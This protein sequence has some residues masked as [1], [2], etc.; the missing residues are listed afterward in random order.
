MRYPA[1]GAVTRFLREYGDELA[2]QRLVVFG[3]NAPYFLDATEMSRLTTYFGV[4]SKTQPFLEN[5]VRGLFRAFTTAG[6]PPVSVP[7]TRFASLSERLAP[8]PTAVMPLQVKSAEGELLLAN[9]A[10]GVTAPDPAA[11]AAAETQPVDVGDT[12][13]LSVGPIIDRNGHPVPDGT[14]VEFDLKFDDEELAMAVDP[15]LTRGGVAA[16]DVAVERSGTLRVAATAGGASSGEP[17]LLVIVPPPA[18]T[19]EAPA[20]ATDTVSAGQQP[21]PERV[22]LMTLLIALF[23]IVVTLSLF[24]IVQV[25]VLPRVRRSSTTCCGPRSSDCSAT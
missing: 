12:L 14:L 16:R 21:L 15:A 7:G 20:D 17:L 13:N 2:E 8:N 24:L 19:V 23:T 10:A 1:S 5:A 18:A 4:Y 9:S 22:N 25:R 11:Q 6:A 3:L